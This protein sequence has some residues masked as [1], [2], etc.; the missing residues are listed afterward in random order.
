[1]LFPVAIAGDS[2]IYGDCGTPFI[3]RTLTGPGTLAIH[4]V[5]NGQAILSV[6]GVDT[7]N[8]TGGCFAGNIQTVAIVGAGAHTIRIDRM[9]D[10]S[11]GCQWWSWGFDGI[12]WNGIPPAEPSEPDSPTVDKQ[13]NI[14]TGGDPVQ[15]LSGAVSLKP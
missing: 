13:E 12:E 8:L 2:D 3:T 7:L 11:A 6:D 10:I 5:D 9:Q 15:T 1:M 4:Q 14:G